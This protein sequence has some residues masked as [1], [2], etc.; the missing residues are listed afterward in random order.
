MLYRW[1]FGNRWAFVADRGRIKIRR[2]GPWMWHLCLGS[3]GEHSAIGSPAS[4]RRRVPS[5][6]STAPRPRRRCPCGL[7]F[8]CQRLLST[9]NL[10]D[11][12]TSHVNICFWRYKPNIYQTNRSEKEKWKS[13]AVLT[14][15]LITKVKELITNK[16]VKWKAAS[17]QTNFIFL[18]STNW[19][20]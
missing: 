16:W 10:C 12:A 20:K 15:S 9:A 11:C 6:W 8:K 5:D 18:T 19:Y 13:T 3:G 4:P 2:R 14:T 17:F 1:V 7:I